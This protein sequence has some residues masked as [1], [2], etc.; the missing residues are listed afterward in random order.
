MGFA[1]IL[2]LL[3]IAVSYLTP[4]EMAPGLAPY[5]IGLILAG[6]TALASTINLLGG[7]YSFQAFQVYAAIM[8]LGATMLS[9]MATGWLG[10]AVV[11]VVSF[12]PAVAAMVFV[13]VNVNTMRRI[14]LLALL[15]IGLSLFLTIQGAMGYY[16]GYREEE[17]IVKQWASMEEESTGVPSL[18]RM[19]AFGF[20]ADPNDLAQQF[21]V[22][23]PFVL[24][25]WRKRAPIRNLLLVM[26]PMVLLMW[27]IYMT[28]S[29]GAI[30]GLTVLIFLLAREKL[31]WIGAGL[32]TAVGAVG[33]LGLSFGGG[34]S[35]SMQEGSAGGRAEAW[36]TGLAEL[37]GHPIFGVGYTRFT[38]YHT[39]TAHNMFVL[40][41][42]ETGMLGYLLFMLMLTIGLLE[43]HR[44]CH[45]K[46]ENEEEQERVRWA[47]AL[48]ISIICFLATGWFLS[49]TY[50]PSLY[51]YLGMGVAL[52]EMDRR[53]RKPV[54]TGFDEGWVVKSLAASVGIIALVYAIVR[55]RWSG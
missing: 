35:L 5:R 45:A 38:E 24:A 43:L 21:T 14:K 3:F 6:L 12:A 17:L 22:V 54:L 7:M 29:R 48:F 20:L 53:S 37:I 30:V 31:K 34:R 1:Y 47:K 55:L 19:R 32:T 2:T 26:I 49:R 42:T 11:A 15:L 27:G 18:R 36:G 28:G 23:M 8:F 50:A 10:G 13:G 33:L 44:L 16:L 41:M 51:V 25:F 4:A 52:A 9:L 40:C 39:I 46:V